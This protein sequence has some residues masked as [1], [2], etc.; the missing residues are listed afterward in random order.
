MQGTT[1]NSTYYNMAYNDQSIKQVSG[2]TYACN[3]ISAMFDCQDTSTHKVRL[4]VYGTHDFE[5]QGAAGDG[6]TYFTA[7]RL[8]DT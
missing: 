2:M 4:Q 6:H 7:I 8:G 3:Y 1:N 5:V